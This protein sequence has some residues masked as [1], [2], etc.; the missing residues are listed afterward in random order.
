MLSL[1]ACYVCVISL[2]CALPRFKGRSV[3]RAA[4]LSMVQL[5]SLQWNRPSLMVLE[6]F[7]SMPIV[8][9]CLGVLTTMASTDLI[10]IHEG[11]PQ[12][13]SYLDLFFVLGKWQHDLGL[14]DVN[15]SLLLSLL[16]LQ[17]SLTAFCCREK[18]PIWLAG[19]RWLSAQWNYIIDSLLIIL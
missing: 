14:G 6:D 16:T 9:N 17:C 11:T 7:N 3:K 10:Q 4:Y 18:D 1:H 19:P 8:R 5:L 12:Q 15:I 2:K 13:R